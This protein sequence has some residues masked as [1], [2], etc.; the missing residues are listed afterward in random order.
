MPVNLL[1][2]NLIAA[3]DFTRGSVFENQAGYG[4]LARTA[5]DFDRG[6]VMNSTSAKAE[7]TATESMKIGFP[8]TIAVVIKRLGTVG[9]NSGIF[10]LV[11]NNANADPYHS[12]CLF[13]T[14]LKQLAFGSNSAGAFYADDLLSEPPLNRWVVCVYE[15]LP[16]GGRGWVDQS[17]ATT[18]TA[19]PW[20]APAFNATALLFAGSYTGTSRNANTE[21]AAG[22]IWNAACGEM[23]N[24]ELNKDWFAPLR[25]MEYHRSYKAAAAASFRPAWASQRT[26]IIGGGSR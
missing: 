20:S 23:V 19:G 4:T 2:K 5:G 15:R 16:G 24:R 18:I 17:L 10:G 26:Q 1:R 7:M 13:Y 12:G 25:R 8:I 21:I 11:H 3:V 22:Y 14:N 9:G 6:F